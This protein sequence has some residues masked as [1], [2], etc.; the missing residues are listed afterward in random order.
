MRVLY[1]DIDGV[2]L[3]YDDK[4][5]P[6]LLDGELQT[7]LQQ[8]GF[9]RLVCVSG[10]CDVVSEPILRI[11]ESN[12][13]LALHDIVRALFPDKAWF[14]KHAEIKTDTDHRCRHIDLNADWFYVDDWA[15]KFFSE[16][17]GGDQYLQFLGTR[18][19]LC[20][21]RGG[22]EDILDWLRGIA[23]KHLATAE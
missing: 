7:L 14:L 22:G 8:K 11:P 20:D 19:L 10:W 16:Q 15:D 5:K 12:R 9:H 6:A 23:G 2:L 21:P 4:P 1:F 3:N 17:F 18:I 13:V